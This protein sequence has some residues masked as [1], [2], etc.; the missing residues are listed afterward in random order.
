MLCCHQ[1]HL[2]LRCYC[3]CQVA[4]LVLAAV[5]AAH[6]C[7]RCCLCSLIGLAGGFV[8]GVAGRSAADQS[9]QSRQLLWSSGAN[10]AHMMFCALQ[11]SNIEG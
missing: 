6:C 5:G 10:D 3:R 7:S 1:L 2:L 9:R 11:Q 8:G 4:S